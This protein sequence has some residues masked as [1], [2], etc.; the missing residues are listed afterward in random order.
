MFDHIHY[1]P[2]ASCMLTRMIINFISSLFICLLHVII[3][4]KKKQ[5]EN[6]ALNLFIGEWM[7]CVLVNVSDYHIKQHKWF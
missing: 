5:D 3:K 6:N 2:I 1:R 4:F 7:M